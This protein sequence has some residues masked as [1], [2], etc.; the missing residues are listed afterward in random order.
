LCK[1]YN[2]QV[3]KNMY[4][5]IQQEPLKVTTFETKTD[6]ANYLNIHRN[7]IN[8][9][10]ADKEFWESDKGLVYQSNKHYKI[11]R[12]GNRDSM[13]TKIRKRNGEIELKHPKK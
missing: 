12:S 5:V 13:E 1:S 2:K 11:S 9:R 10:F 7:T 6:L 8:N 3:T 4:I